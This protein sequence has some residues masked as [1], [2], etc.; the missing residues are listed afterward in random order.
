M[1]KIFLNGT[2]W[3]GSSDLAEL[4]LKIIQK[5]ITT[6]IHHSLYPFSNEGSTVWAYFAKAFVDLS[7]LDFEV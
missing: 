7:G 6:P 1:R 4:I 2:F 3:I 5:S